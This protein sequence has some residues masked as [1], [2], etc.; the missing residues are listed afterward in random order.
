M[1]DATGVNNVSGG[2]LDVEAKKTGKTME[3]PTEEKQKDLDKKI[4]KGGD[5]N[6]KYKARKKRHSAV[7]HSGIKDKRQS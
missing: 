7:G 5:G 2:S 6:I 1:S 4:E 3:E